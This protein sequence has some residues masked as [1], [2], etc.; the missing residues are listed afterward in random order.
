VLVM[1]FLAVSVLV[2]RR[3]IARIAAWRRKHSRP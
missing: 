3:R 1:A 2:I